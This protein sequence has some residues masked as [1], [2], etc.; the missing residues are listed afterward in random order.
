MRKM[1]FIAERSVL[2]MGTS[3]N[4][5]IAET[6]IQLPGENAKLRIER[7]F[8]RRVRTNDQYEQ[9]TT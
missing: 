2:R 6:T 3:L 1:G 9:R 7:L 8:S 5:I 4:M